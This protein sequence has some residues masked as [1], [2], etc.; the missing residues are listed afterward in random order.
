VRGY[1]LAHKAFPHET[2]ADQWFTESQLESYRALGFEIM[3]GI[4]T[5]GAE[6]LG[7]DVTLDLILEALEH[8]AA[9]AAAKQRKSAVQPPCAVRTC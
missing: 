7:N 4:L 5:K 6:D 8:E 3:D 1:A 9:A 2:T